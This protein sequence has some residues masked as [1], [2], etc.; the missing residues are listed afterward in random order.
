MR[1]GGVFEA[2]TFGGA[3][4]SVSGTTVAQTGQWY[5]VVATAQ[6]NGTM[7]LFVNGVEEGS[8]ATLTG[9]LWTGGDRYLIGSQS[10]GA[11]NFFAGYIDEV[12][13]YDTVLAPQ[14]IM[15]HFA[16]GMGIIPEPASALL[17]VAGALLAGRRFPGCRRPTRR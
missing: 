2:Y 16:A 7:R 6:G 13:F 5:H 14:R 9:S 11:P 4:R 8:P 12:A 1:A 3:Q 17:L 15:A 10:S